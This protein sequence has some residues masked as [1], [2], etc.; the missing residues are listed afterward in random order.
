MAA[1]AESPL[2]GN[3]SLGADS[4][5]RSPVVT[6]PTV[7][8]APPST[9][10][11]PGPSPASSLAPPPRPSRFGPI[12]SLDGLR[13][14]AVLIV[15]VSHAGYGDVI[16]G[17]LGVTIF[18]FLSG[19][20]ITTLMLDEWG[21]KGTV[22][23]KHFYGRRALRLLPSLFVT[24]AVAY[25]LVGIGRLSGGVSWQGLSSQLFYFANYYTIFFDHG[26][27]VPDGTGIL[28]SLAVEEHFYILFPL[29]MVVVLRFANS[30]RFLIGLFAVL[31]TLAL[32][33]RLYLATRPGFVELRTY[34][35]SDTRFDSIL[36]GAL[37]ALCANPARRPATDV[38]VG[39]RRMRLSEQLL[40]AGGF[41][42]LLATILYRQPVF[43]ESFRYT[44]QGIALLPLF[45]YAVTYPAA[46]VFRVLNT[47][48]LVRIGVLSYGIYLI[49]DVILYLLPIDV[50]IPNWGRFLIAVAAAVGFAELLDRCVD[51]YFRRKRAALR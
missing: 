11:A 37:L 29:L 45:Y 42:L 35:G 13:A 33:W 16:P 17:G 51:P 48:L 49:H 44:L 6:S 3:M 22:N 5:A 50:H 12:P 34:Y 40:V 2:R 8:L 20:L 23:V 32:G 25:L 47:R 38:P 36:F 14:L 30:R 39:P 10:P 15:V 46:G 24:L 4:P 43:R 9:A 27:T 18:F 1:G 41:A 19:F 7:D 31:C 28:W 26:N 21:Q